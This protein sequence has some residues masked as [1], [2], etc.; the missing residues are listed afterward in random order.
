MLSSLKGKIFGNKEN[1]DENSEI[2]IMKEENKILKDKLKGLYEEN[3]KMKQVMLLEEKEASKTSNIKKMFKDFK[4]FLF[5]NNESN[6]IQSF[7]RYLSENLIYSNIDEEDIDYLNS[8]DVT[9]QNW[10]EN[11]HI[12]KFKQRILDKNYKEMFKNVIILNEIK[13]F[14]KNKNKFYN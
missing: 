7:K 3:E 12:Y 1:K 6:S 8:I 5:Y 2:D 4:I 13:D 9:D 11:K 10:V 14:E